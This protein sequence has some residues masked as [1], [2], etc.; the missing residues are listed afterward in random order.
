MVNGI[1]TEPVI[2]GIDPGTTSAVAVL[3]LDNDLKGYKSAKNFSKDQIIQF[4]ISHGKPLIIAT[5]VANVPS[6]IDGIASNMGATLYA[7]NEDLKA[8]YKEELT[9]RFPIQGEDTHTMDAAAAAAYAYREYED[10]LASIREKAADAGLDREARFDVV[11]LVFNGSLSTQAAIREV[12]KGGTETNREK[13]ERSNNKDWKRI[14]EKRKQQID[15]LQDKV[16][17]LEE[18]KD[19]LEEQLADAEEVN[20][21]AVD[22]EE[23]R[24]RNRVINRLRSELSE[25]KTALETA[26]EENEVLDTA[27]DRVLHHNWTY[28]PKVNGLQSVSHDIVYCDTYD[29]G[30]VSNS[31]DTILTTRTVQDSGAYKSLAE[32]GISIV[33]VSTLPEALDVEH[34]YVVPPDELH[35]TVS[36]TDDESERFLEWLETYKKR[37]T[38]S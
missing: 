32:N 37:Q 27:L 17:R 36:T 35:S 28:V 21:N 31:I 22:E 8:R 7:P 25:T 4:I 10:K 29:G 26:Q 38:T 18:Y 15:R 19:M 30:T 6:L 9:G 34:G 24:E 3:G 12:K 2:V 16:E 20:E 11:E 5:D 13:Q 23:L 1:T 14:A 33:D